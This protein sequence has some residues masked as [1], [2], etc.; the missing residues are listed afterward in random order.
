MMVS[1]SSQVGLS[2]GTTAWSMKIRLAV[3]RLSES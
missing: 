3:D 2:W 1:A